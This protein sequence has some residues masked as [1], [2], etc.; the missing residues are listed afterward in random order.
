MTEPASRADGNHQPVPEAISHA[1]VVALDEQPG[2][3]QQ[4][5]GETLFHERLSQAVAHRRR[6]SQPQRLS[7]GIGDAA[8]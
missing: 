1:A 2:A 4:P 7:R 8:P 6:E 5:F 3:E